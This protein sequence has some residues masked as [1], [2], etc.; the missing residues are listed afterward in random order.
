[1]SNG[2]VGSSIESPRSL[3][4][5]GGRQVQDTGVAP[6]DDGFTILERRTAT[7]TEEGFRRDP[8]REMSFVPLLVLKGIYH[9]WI[10]FPRGLK[11]ME[12]VALAC[13][14]VGNS[15]GVGLRREAK[16]KSLPIW[17]VQP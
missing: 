14:G 2:G 7:D 4:D 5:V 13:V 16:S 6:T 3:W 9:Y 12:G 10:F 15:C 1:M 11:Q 17:G 8:L